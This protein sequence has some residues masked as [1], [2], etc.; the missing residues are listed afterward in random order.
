MKLVRSSV[1]ANILMK[2]RSKAF[3]IPNLSIDTLSTIHLCDYIFFIMPLY[4][5]YF[6]VGI[7][8]VA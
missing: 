3:R 7:A 4:P 5:E 6:L 1:F 8:C 2:I